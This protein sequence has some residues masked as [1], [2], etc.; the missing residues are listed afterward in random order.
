M[1]T[2]KILYMKDCGTSFHGKHL[3]TALEYITAAEKTQDRRLVAG[4]NCQPELA[5]EQMRETKRRFGKTDKRQAYHLIISFVENEVDADTAFALAGKFVEAY[6]GDNYEAVYAVHDNTNHIHAHIVFNSVSFMDG[7]KY[8]YEKGDWEKVIQPLVN[9][10]CEEYGLS[11]LEIGTDR[12]KGTG[13]EWDEHRDGPFVWSDMIKRD[14]DISVAQAASYDEF[15]QVLSGKG[16]EIKYGKYTAIKPMGM[17][18]YRRLRSLGE[19]YTE[20]R[21]RERVLRENLLTYKGETLEEVERIVYSMIPRG[22]RTKLSGLQKKYY[23]RLYR[24]GLIKQRPYSQAWK[25]KDD[26]RRMKQ[27]QEQYLF[28]VNHDVESVENLLDVKV[29]LE[30]EKREVSKEK[31][32]AYRQ[33][34]RCNDL[35][36]IA[37]AMKELQPAEMAYRAGDEFFEEEHTRWMRQEQELQSKG[38]SYEEVVKLKEHYRGEIIRAREL[39]QLVKKKIRIAETI[40]REAGESQKEID[41]E[42]EK[43]IKRDEQPRL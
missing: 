30:E 23:A 6:L 9:R 19:E 36:A 3:K 11:S 5:F 2:S 35:F 15:L 42:E 31:S 34:S 17:R 16:Y 8:R 40:L 21:L 25:Y 4:V 1:A 13:G 10:L 24:L 28:L 39:E 32:K 18:K 14:I 27:L 26:I 41:R 43:N 12:T 37:D 33:R 38:Y 7:R 22:K 20:E 29:T